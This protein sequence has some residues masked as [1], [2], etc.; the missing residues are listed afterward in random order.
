MYS[1][2]VAYAGRQLL[3]RETEDE[4]V[5]LVG[6]R[7]EEVARHRLAG[8]TNQRVVVPA[9]YAALRLSDWATVPPPTLATSAMPLPAATVLPHLPDAPLVEVRT[10][11]D[12]DRLLGV[13]L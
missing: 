11:A 13:A 12:Y 9:H 10:L 5:V 7:G 6:P 4:A 1:V 3:V 2:P 8:G